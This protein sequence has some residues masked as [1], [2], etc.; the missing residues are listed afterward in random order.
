MELSMLDP[1]M[2]T[3]VP[4]WSVFHHSTEYLMMGR[5]IAPMSRRWR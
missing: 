1:R 5:L 3:L 4:W 2:P